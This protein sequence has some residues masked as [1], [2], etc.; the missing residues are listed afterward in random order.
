[1]PDDQ[2]RGDAEQH[3]R[4]EDR[5]GCGKN[6]PE[7]QRL[8]PPELHLGSRAIFRLIHKFWG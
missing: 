2:D 4:D 6:E 5:S 3:E 1:M 7:P 8:W